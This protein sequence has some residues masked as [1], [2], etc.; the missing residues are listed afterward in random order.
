MVNPGRLKPIAAVGYLKK[1][2]VE[3]LLPSFGRKSVSKFHGHIPPSATTNCQGGTYGHQIVYPFKGTVQTRCQLYS[4]VT[5]CVKDENVTN[6]L[7]EII[8]WY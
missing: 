1:S 8:G 3:K 5:S 2:Y 4:D 6:G 7:V